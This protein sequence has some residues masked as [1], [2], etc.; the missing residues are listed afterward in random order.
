M[1]DY[2]VSDY[3]FDFF[4][5]KGISLRDDRLH[6]FRISKEFAKTM[7]YNKMK[8]VEYYNYTLS[9]MLVNY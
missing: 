6:H 8:N 3:C 1:K 7:F 5:F 9:K 4:F 2:L